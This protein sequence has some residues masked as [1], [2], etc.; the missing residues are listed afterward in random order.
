MYTSVAIEQFFSKFQEQFE[1]YN[2]VG[3]VYD[4]KMNFSKLKPYILNTQDDE[5]RD[6]AWMGIIYTRQAVSNGEPFYRKWVL[7]EDFYDEETGK[8]LAYKCSQCSCEVNFLIVSNELM[9]LEALENE[10]HWFYDGR[11]EMKIALNKL[12]EFKLD[13]SDITYGEFTKYDSDE[14]G[15]L[16]SL[17][18]AVRLNYPILLRDN[19]M[20]VIKRIN[21]LIGQNLPDN[22]FYSSQIG[23]ST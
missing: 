4:P 2:F 22:V 21:Y 11:Y 23:E 14:Y 12:P 16:C 1:A 6:K 13:I 19:D 10:L 9:H 18:M 15:K 5:D 17:G 20:T 7:H 8:V 3:A